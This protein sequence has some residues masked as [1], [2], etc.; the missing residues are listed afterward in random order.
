[1]ALILILSKEAFNGGIVSFPPS[2][3]SGEMA[4]QSVCLTGDVSNCLLKSITTPSQGSMLD[5]MRF[6]PLLSCQDS[7]MSL[8]YARVRHIW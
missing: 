3:G 2:R 5:I 1:M 7:F 6:S 4:Y 8:F